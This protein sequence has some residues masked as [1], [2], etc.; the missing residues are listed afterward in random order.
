LAAFLVSPILITSA[1]AYTSFVPKITKWTIFIF[2]KNQQVN[3]LLCFDKLAGQPGAVTQVR[4]M[5]QKCV[6]YL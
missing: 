2:T 3:A 4:Q 1:F 5:P 6:Q